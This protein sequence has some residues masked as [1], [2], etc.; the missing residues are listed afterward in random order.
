MLV[1]SGVTDPVRLARCVRDGAV[2]IVDKGRG[3]ASLQ[4][5][6]ERVLERG[7]LLAPHEREEHLAWLRRHDSDE[8]H[9]LAPFHEL[10]SREA[11]V[12]RALCH[13]RSVDQ[14]ARDAVVAV[15]TVRTQVR[16]ILRKLGVGSQLAATAMAHET[17]WVD[18]D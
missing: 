13:G 2:G 1:V 4:Q 9:R 7:T 12:L 3:L 6:I 10:T 11:E 17:G 8:R 15:S 18:Q 5:S 14:I 16:A